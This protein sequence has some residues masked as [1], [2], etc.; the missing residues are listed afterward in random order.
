MDVKIKYVK[1]INNQA[2][3]YKLSLSL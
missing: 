3:D 1:K 2:K